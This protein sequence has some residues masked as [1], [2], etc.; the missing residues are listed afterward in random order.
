[1]A[2]EVMEG[3]APDDAA[4][5]RRLMSAWGMLA[6]LCFADLL[7]LVPDRTP[8]PTSFT[9][10]G[11]MRPSTNPTLYREDMVGRR[12]TVEEKPL[13]DQSLRLGT[14][15][16]GELH[17]PGQEQAR[18]QA[19][20][21]RR[22][23]R[24][25]GV[26]TRESAPQVG[27]RQGELERVYV[28]T[29]DRFARMIASG[30]FPF[31]VGEE[32]EG[33][34]PRVGDGVLIVDARARVVYASPNAVSALH[35]MQVHS[36]VV[37]AR[38]SELGLETTAIERALAAAVPVTEEVERRPDVIVLVRCLPLLEEGSPTGG[39]V[40]VRDVTDLRRRD[41]LLVSKDATIREVH[42]RVKNN[43][44]TI[45][46][47]LRLQGR[48]LGSAEGRTALQEAERRIR[49]I[50]VVHE[51]LSRDPGDQVAFGEIVHALVR[52]AEES[53]ISYDRRVRIRNYGE[54][55]EVPAGVATP[56]AVVMAELLQNAVEHA[57]VGDGR[58]DEEGLRVDVQFDNDGVELAVSVSD[59]GR[60]LPP[61]FD[62][63]AT[64]SLGLSLVRDLV[65]GQLAGSISMGTAD[66]FGTRVELH[67][68][69]P[70]PEGLA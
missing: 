13:A 6:D 59:N 49:S 43:L 47:L 18:V 48:R 40:L 29:F 63:A 14:I 22:H 9:V 7:L 70:E 31:A 30:E 34:S 46:S 53:A 23:D 56:L 8:A 45:S 61:G 36:N 57:F 55:G 44:Q 11:Q 38:L 5:L 60:G 42:H 52:M 39:I 62:V 19:I 66:D 20:P 1:M 24:V 26:L 33:E 51:I 67:I 32:R 4:H 35:R 68:P 2:I 3:I 21:V 54:A 12:F 64:D 10:A 58:W 27:R 16:E 69:L 17:S 25:L 37:G 28:E 15:V 65:T 50:A 41:R